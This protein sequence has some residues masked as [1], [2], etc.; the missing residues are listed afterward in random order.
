MA[1][2]SEEHLVYMLRTTQEPST[3]NPAPKR[4]VDSQ[5]NAPKPDMNKQLREAKQEER[6]ISNS[7]PKANDTRVMLM[8]CLLPRV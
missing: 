5:A 2:V 3:I 4:V 1:L 6:G 8:Q 7:T